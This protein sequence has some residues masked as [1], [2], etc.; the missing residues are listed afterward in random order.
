MVVCPSGRLRLSHGPPRIIGEKFTVF[1][2]CVTVTVVGQDN[3]W[4]SSGNVMVVLPL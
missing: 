4:P 2:D 3:V 1:P